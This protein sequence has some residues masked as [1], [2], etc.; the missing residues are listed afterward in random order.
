MPLLGG[1]GEK[2][3]LAGVDLSLLGEIGVGQI[4]V[5]AED[6][7]HARREAFVRDILELHPG[8]L[9]D[10]RRE[11]VAGRGERR[12]DRDL[13]GALLRVGEELLP[14]LPRRLR[15]CR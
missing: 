7:V 10:Q 6:R 2:L 4:D 8:G 14:A 3:E 5:T 11:E 1:D 9:L 15:A 12:A 13:S